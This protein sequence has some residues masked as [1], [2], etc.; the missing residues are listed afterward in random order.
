LPAVTSAEILSDL[1]VQQLEQEIRPDPTGGLGGPIEGF[2][3]PRAGARTKVGKHGRPKHQGPFRLD[4]PDANRPNPPEASSGDSSMQATGVGAYNPWKGMDQQVIQAVYWDAAAEVGKRLSQV[5]SALQSHGERD[6]WV[7]L[8]S[9]NGISL[10]E[11]SGS[12]SYPHDFAFY[13]LIL[14]RTVHVPLVFLG[15]GTGRRTVKQPVEMVNLLP[16]L[17]GLAGA[18]VPQGVSGHDL[19]S[20]PFKPDA[21]AAA[22]MEFGDMLAIRQ[23]P[24][25]LTVRAMVHNTTSLQPMLTRYIERDG[26][27]KGYWLHD[28]V[29]DPM[30][31]QDGIPDSYQVA[32]RLKERLVEYRTGPGALPAELVDSPLLREAL[33]LESTGYW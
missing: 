3:G 12:K 31:E 17:L 29:T 19:F 6:R 11:L 15:P 4:G 1:P 14:D 28:V 27:D 33:E 26:L 16:T 30:Q 23:G 18:V 24:Y 25:L 8:S 32:L 22:Y 9:T 2:A 5:L 21:E 13:Q 10:G 7:V 20:G